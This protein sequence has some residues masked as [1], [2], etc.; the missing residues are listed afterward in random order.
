[1]G[2]DGPS[3]SPSP[4]PPRPPPLRPT[5]MLHHGLLMLVG[6]RRHRGSGPTPIR[7]HI[8]GFTCV[9]SEM[10]VTY[11][12]VALRGV[13]YARSETAR[14]SRR[15]VVISRRKRSSGSLSRQSFCD[16]GAAVGLGVGCEGSWGGGGWGGARCRAGRAENVLHLTSAMDCA[17]A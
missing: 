2:L 14:S 7:L 3:P 15:M 16:R 9:E 1:M 13:M 12:Y 10:D 6:S 5:R 17:M 11:H 4:P 8:S